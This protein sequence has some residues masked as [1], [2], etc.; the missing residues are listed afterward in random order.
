MLAK[1]NISSNFDLE[2]QFEE[3][4]KKKFFFIVSAGRSGKALFSGLV[5]SNKKILIMH[6]S[7]K[8]LSEINYIIKIDK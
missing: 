4:K 6:F 2:S 8:I 1:K 5:D 3:F 7:N